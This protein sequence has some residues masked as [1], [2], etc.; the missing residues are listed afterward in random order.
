MIASNISHEGIVKT[1]IFK[2]KDV[3][4]E[5]IEEINFIILRRVLNLEILRNIQKRRIC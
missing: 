5:E 3:S 4:L 2:G 1:E